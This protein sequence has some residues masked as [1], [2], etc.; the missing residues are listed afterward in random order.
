MKQ[1]DFGTLLD[2]SESYLDNQYHIEQFLMTI[3]LIQFECYQIEKSVNEDD[4]DNSI[5]A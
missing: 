3:A 1:D 5:A 4:Y 2:S